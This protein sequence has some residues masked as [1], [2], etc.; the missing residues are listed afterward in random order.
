MDIQKALSHKKIVILSLVTIFLCF[1]ATTSIS[2]H[3][4]SKVIEAHDENAARLIATNIHAHIR[5]FLSTHTS[6]AK[7]MAEDFFV[8]IA[9]REDAKKSD[10]EPGMPTLSRFLDG[11]VRTTAIDTAYIVS[12]ATHRYFSHLGLHK[13]IA[14]D[15]AENPAH[16][17]DTWYPAFIKT[18]MNRNIQIDTNPVVSD[19]WTIFFNN[20]I[21]DDDATLLGVCGVGISMK[22][23]Q[24][25]LHD[26]EI[27]YGVEILMVDDTETSHIGSRQVSIDK[28]YL[29]LKESAASAQAISFLRTENNSWQCRVELNQFGW[30][31]IINQ[32]GR[33]VVKTF[34]F[35]ILNNILLF[36]CIFGVMFF[37][38]HKINRSEKEVLTNMARIDV[39]TG[40]ENRSAVD[41]VHGMLQADSSPGTFF[42]ID[43]DGFK[44]INDTLG[45]PF[46]DILLRRIGGILQS[47]FRKSDVVSRIGGDEFM[48]YSPG[49]HE[50]ENVRVKAQQM[51]NDIQEIHRLREFPNATDIHISISMGIALF[52]QHGNT[53]DELYHCA[54]KA[55]YQAKAAGKNRFI[56]F[57][58]SASRT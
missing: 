45:H 20:R 30:K 54:D 25:L 17:H 8:K 39:L 35:I 5:D 26:L 57:D 40:I 12:D 38:I 23:L 42:I 14:P 10:L 27:H 4:L 46:G 32:A 37:V 50:I 49:L 3:S 28:R 58:D 33:D 51:E 56:I 47:S 9:L 21:L 22:H 41:R 7:T 24:L 6:A 1:L 16:E 55:L 29:N 13:V 48:I 36:F 43:V 15:K 11:L 53:Y 44:K 19:V 31:L 18:G 34:S 52:P 2:I